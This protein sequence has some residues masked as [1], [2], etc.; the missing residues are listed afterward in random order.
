MPRFSVIVPAFQVAPW[1][2]DCLTSVLGQSFGDFEVLVVD[3][4]STD[5]SGPLADRFAERDARVSVVHLP[6]NRGVGPARNLA[7]ERAVGD[8]V[9]FV[10]GDDIVPPGAFAS[11]DRRLAA[12]G[13]P[14]LLV[15]DFAGFERFG[16][17]TRTGFPEGLAGAALTAF[18]LGR[19]P[20]VLKI[21]L[22]SWNKAYRRAFVADHGFTF[23]VGYY[24]DVLWSLE[25]LLS[26]RTIALHDAVCL[27]YRRNRP[28]SL[29]ATRCRN[30]F[31]LVT[32]YARIF[33]YIERRP[34]LLKWRP[35]ILEISVMGLYPLVD[36]VPAEAVSDFLDLCATH[37]SGH[38]EM[39]AQLRS[40]IDR[41]VHA[42]H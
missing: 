26:A 10:D 5:G 35:K 14:D 7:L 20:D 13:E 29:T 6:D 42:L 2:E 34:Q 25:N 32:Q 4:G 31:D 37:F 9:L 1:V 16:R 12:T 24:E 39:L 3:D 21:P 18:E 17:F 36:L 27:Y 19:H 28:G 40:K 15:Y 11:I 30:H 8:Y 38:P 22:A 33:S 41:S 23:P